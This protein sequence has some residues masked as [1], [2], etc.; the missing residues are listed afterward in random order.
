MSNPPFLIENLI[1]S[2]VEALK[3]R[4]DARAIAVLVAGEAELLLWDDDFGVDSWRLF[5]SLPVSL[6]YAITDD[7]R[8]ATSDVIAEAVRPFFA[9]TPRANLASVVIAPKVTAAKQGWR[10]DA[11]RFVKGEGV[12]NQGRV[13]SD[14][15]GP[16][17]P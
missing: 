14:N 7:E 17:W 2:S 1:A 4:G 9:A 12:T 10:D 8:E 15:I 16:T 6:F 11:L 13:R 3:V 5:V